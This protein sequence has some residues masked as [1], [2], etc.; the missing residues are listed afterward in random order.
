MKNIAIT[1]CDD[2]DEGAEW[3]LKVVWFIFLLFQ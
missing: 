1:S 3:L 2:L